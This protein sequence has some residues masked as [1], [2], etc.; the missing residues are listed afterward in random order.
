MLHKDLKN[1][2]T[3]DVLES[4][5]PPQLSNDFFEALYG[6]VDEGAY[7]ISLSF[8]NYDPKK[9]TL[10]F[11][12]QLHERVDK[13]LVCNLTYGLPEVFSNHPLINIKGLVEK[14]EA[15][16]G[17]DIKCSGWELG[18]TQ[19]PAAT[20]HTIPLIIQLG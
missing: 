12:L 15:I 19:T 2:F 17:D 10:S 9:R 16:L 7:N 20:M 18:R 5:L 1:L 14:I 13:C 8:K 11:E 4:L 3:K 6:D